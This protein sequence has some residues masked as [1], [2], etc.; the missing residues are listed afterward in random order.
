MNCHERMNA[1]LSRQQPDRVPLFSC[2]EEQNQIY[3]ILGEQGGAPVR[4]TADRGPVVRISARS[5]LGGDG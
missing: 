4:A 5:L 2:T 3:E 1:A